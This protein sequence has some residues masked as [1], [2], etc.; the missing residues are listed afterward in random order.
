MS[1][2]WT[3]TSVLLV[4]LTLNMVVYAKL[5]K[6]LGSYLNYYTPIV[7]LDYIINYF[8][9]IFSYSASG[10][11]SKF[12]SFIII[13]LLNF[14]SIFF[15]LLGALCVGKK[16]RIELFSVQSNKSKYFLEASFSFAVGLLL[17][18]PLF[19]TYGLNIYTRA[20]E[21]YT[22][23]RTG[24]GGSSFL[25]PFFLC[26][27]LAFILFSI[28]KK[29][30]ISRLAPVAA[31]Y[32]MVIYAL[33]SK[34]K[35]LKAIEVVYFWA[36]QRWRIR[37]NAVIFFVILL[38]APVGG[39]LI[40]A[41]FKTTNTNM[42]VVSL[43]SGA[44]AYSDYNKNAELALDSDQDLTYGQI[45]FE[46]YFISKV[47]RFM[48]PDKPK[49]FGEF[50]LAKKYYPDWFE[51]DTGAPSFGKLSIYLDFWIFAFLLIPV[52]SMIN[53]AIIRA[54]S[55]STSVHD[56]PYAFIIFTDLLGV[57][58]LSAGVGSFFIELLVTLSIFY[59]LRFSRI[60]S[61]RLFKK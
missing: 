46:N 50:R 6:R 45:Y 61:F 15:L 16:Y 20:R 8:L 41:M 1:E 34:G 11:Y 30:K 49:D 54:V 7:V 17:L 43:L 23:T 21:I 2:F 52:F 3:R 40:I 55:N 10:D 4:L 58:Y 35:I 33:G 22:E 44:S 28:R 42:D 53:G 24:W 39:A 9:E 56:S 37:V 19:A 26:I 38:M 5:S 13:S 12:S 36:I 59:I 29:P 31:A 48:Y 14:C 25:A 32:I 57:N 51:R 47:P 27:S 18:Y 60:P